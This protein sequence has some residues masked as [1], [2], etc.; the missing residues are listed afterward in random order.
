MK[1]GSVAAQTVIENKRRRSLNAQARQPKCGPDDQRTTTKP[2]RANILQQTK[3]GQ[4]TG[5]YTSLT[6]HEA[7]ALCLKVAENCLHSTLTQ[8]R[9]T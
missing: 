9:R 5:A 1:T 6:A 2:G 3:P 7:A 8:R 4:A